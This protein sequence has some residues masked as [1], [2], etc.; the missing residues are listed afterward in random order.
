MIVLLVFSFLAG[1]VTILSPCI[2][3]VLPIVLS[4]A[5]GEG[6]K[7]PLGIVLGFVLSFTFF[8]LFLAII[9]KALEISSELLRNLSITIIF[10]FGISLLFSQIQVFLE[11]IFSKF[12]SALP[13]TQNKEGFLGGIVVGLSLGLIWTPCVGPII[14]SVIA[15]A[16]TSSVTLETFL[17]TLAYSLGTAIPMFL[18]MLGGRR[19]L[20][21][22]AKI[23]K[24]FGVVMIVTAVMIFFNFDRKFQTYILETFPQYGAGITKIEDNSLVR[25]ELLQALTSGQKAPE[26]IAGGE[27]VNSKPLKISDLKGKVVLVDFWTY[28]CINCIRT[29]PYLKDWDKKYGDKGLVIIGVHTPEFQ[30]EKN[31]TNVKK[32]IADFGIKYPVVQDNDFATW[33][34]YDNHF[35]PAK[36]F[37]DKNGIVRSRHF[38]EGEYDNSEK[39][40]QQLL[41][42]TGEDVSGIKISNKKYE[43]FTETPETYL[44]YARMERMGSPEEVVRDEV[45]DYSLPKNLPNDEFALSGKWLVGAE[46]SMPKT[47]AKLIFN[48]GAK[49]VYLVMRTTDGKTGKVRVGSKIIEIK[50]DKLYQLVDFPE[51]KRAILEIE[52]LTPNIEVY[53]FTFG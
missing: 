9:V 52:F 43:I 41:S 21:N 35:W 25:K 7:R 49:D 47:G 28:T 3:P 2:L 13:Q 33:N 4:G 15:L 11:K 30:F 10:L 34:A 36:Y 27:W 46:R 12:S 20:P 14:A 37:I 51:P 24:A 32:A 5:V 6:K 23:Q 42:E 17:I 26:I 44:G 18:I 8:T 45:S 29:L 31:P 16:V 40:I 38:G 48:F 53:A 1:I 50:E 22:S 39:L 19:F